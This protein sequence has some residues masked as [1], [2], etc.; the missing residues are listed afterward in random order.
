MLNL[1]LEEPLRVRI[2]LTGLEPHPGIKTPTL[3]LDFFINMKEGGG[4]NP[5]LINQ[6]KGNH[7]ID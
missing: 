7:Q 6:Y 1:R 4:E 3:N 2:G 5:G